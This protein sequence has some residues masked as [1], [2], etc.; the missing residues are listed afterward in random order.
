M[1]SAEK[2]AGYGSRQPCLVVGYLHETA[3]V[4][5]AD[6]NVEPKFSVLILTNLESFERIG[7]FDREDIWANSVPR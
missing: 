3:K 1:F 6:P 2:I 5:N 7:E 4:I